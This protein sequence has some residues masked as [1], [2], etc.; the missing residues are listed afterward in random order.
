MDLWVFCVSACHLAALSLSLSRD[1]LKGVV[2]NPVRVEGDGQ[3]LLD[4]SVT[5]MLLSAFCLIYKPSYGGDNC[6]KQQIDK[7][8]SM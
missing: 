6:Q 2:E 1:A 3:S 7:L 5:V 4:W 8:V